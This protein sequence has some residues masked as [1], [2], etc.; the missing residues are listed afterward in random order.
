MP[1][2]LTVF[3]LCV[4]LHVGSLPALAACPDWPGA[5]AE[6]EIVALHARL[7]GWN[8]AYR[9]DGGSPVSDA[10]YDQ[11]RERLEAWRGCFPG[12]APE[13]SP[14]QAGSAGER[15][16]PVAQTGLAKL[17]GEPAVR[18]WLARRD[19]AWLQ[20]KVDG[21]AVTLVFDDGRLV[22]AIS[23]GDGESGQDWTARLRRLPAV[24][25]RLTEAPPGRVVLQGELYRRLDDHIQA[26]AGGAG[27]RSEVAGWLARERLAPA[28]AAEIGLFVWAWPDGPA[29]MSERLA[30]LAAMGFADTGRWSR[31]VEG[32]ED[33][34]RLRER[35]YRGP[36]PFATDG[37]V[38]KRGGR[39][40]GA[41]WRAEAPGW[42]AAWKYPPREALAEVRGVEFRIG[43]T[44]RIT[45]L[46]QLMPVR[47]DGRTLRRV[48]VGSLSRWQAFDIRPGD[49]VVVAL[50]GA[51]IPR[52]EGVAWRAAE[53][54]EVTPPSP[55]DYYALSCWHPEPGCEGQF[56]ERLAWLSG[57]AA[58]DIPGLGPGTW[59]S[60]IDAGLVEGLLDWLAL[61]P[62]E[63][64]RASGIGDIRAQRLA[65]RFGT[66]RQRPFV[67]WLEA[68]GP[69]PGWAAGPSNGWAAL[70]GRSEAE[71]RALPG[72]GPT[73]AV[74]LAAFF[75]DPEVL[76]LA[77]RLKEVGIAGFAG[78]ASR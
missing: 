64:E 38:L 27:A 52:L 69:P 17:D 65:T 54:P 32:L 47:L 35:W 23:R 61:A 11:A 15:V 20:P 49:S 12:R 45:P 67:A 68:L 75:D 59:R 22:R 76:T 77:S 50:A 10:V 33:A 58:L 46:L 31:A 43:R 44:G 13:A 72:V 62:A 70:A 66:A 71:W 41:G 36:L 21:V 26:Q 51:T 8:D 55:A 63:L 53:R 78:V 74:D 16:H 4:C 56:L 1:R 42:A 60:L 24:P 25:E 6:R 9:R 2:R 57:E 30:G 34:R 18:T 14:P 40:D 5:R 29:A 28:L 3:L 39:P 37:V 73:R 7:E 48:S 19:D